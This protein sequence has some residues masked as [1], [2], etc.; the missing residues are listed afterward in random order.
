MIAKNSLGIVSLL[1]VIFAC[2][3]PLSKGQ[4]FEWYSAALAVRKD[5]SVTPFQHATTKFC[6]Q[7]SAHQLLSIRHGLRK[8]KRYAKA[9]RHE[10]WAR[11]IL[12]DNIPATYHSKLF[13]WLT[14][15][16]LAT[17][18]AN[19]GISE[20]CWVAAPD[21]SHRRR[22]CDFLNEHYLIGLI[23]TT[24][25]YH[26]EENSSNK[27]VPSMG[28]HIC[29]SLVYLPNLNEMKRESQIVNMARVLT[30]WAQQEY[31]GADKS[32]VIS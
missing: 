18:E 6:K 15:Q 3:F 31:G 28:Q 27:S 24:W 14:P 10:I 22:L 29:E 12:L 9:A 1:G 23:N 2:F 25:E 8:T 26:R 16:V 17:H 21:G 30:L 20:F 13:P 4:T 11:R 19:L 7:P 5:K 32:T